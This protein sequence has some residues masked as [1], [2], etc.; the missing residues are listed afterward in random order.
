ME[1]GWW[2]I[3]CEFVIEFLFQDIPIWM[4]FQTETCCCLKANGKINLLRLVVQP[5]QGQMEASGIEGVDKK[6]DL[7]VA[8]PMFRS[9]DTLDW[10]LWAIMNQNKVEYYFFLK[11]ILLKSQHLTELHIKILYT[12][13][14]F[15][16]PYPASH[17]YW[18]RVPF[19]KS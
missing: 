2:N 14:I 17:S 18:A 7:Q 19:K 13:E 11:I 1:S 5:I 16:K 10:K 15:S 3:V 12:S 6:V 8:G 9:R 4:L